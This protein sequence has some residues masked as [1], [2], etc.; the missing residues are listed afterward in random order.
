MKIEIYRLNE[1][2]N[3]KDSNKKQVIFVYL[4]MPSTIVTPNENK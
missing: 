4:F 2:K 1:N 3:L